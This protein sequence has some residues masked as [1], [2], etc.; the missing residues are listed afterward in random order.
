MGERTN[1]EKLK[2][3][4]YIDND[5]DEAYKRG[6][7]TEMWADEMLTNPEAFYWLKMQEIGMVKNPFEEYD[8]LVNPDM[9]VLE[10]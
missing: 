4:Q 1:A 6:F 7:V 5:S 9:L 10:F 8:F 3:L 2:G